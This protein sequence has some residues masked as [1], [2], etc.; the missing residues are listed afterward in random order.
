METSG[1]LDALAARVLERARD[2]AAAAVRR[3]E[4]AAARELERAE[5]QRAE[6]RHA[7]E[8]ASRT[9][10]ERRLHAARAEA[11]QSK[12]RAALNAREAAVEAV[13]EEALRRLRTADDPAGPGKRLEALIREGIAALGAPASVRVQ[14]NAAGQALARAPDFPK[15][16]DGV[17]VS[18]D[19]HAADTVGGAVVTDADGRVIFENTYEAR[20]ARSRE[21]LRRRV[22][23][24]L[25]LQ[26][27][28]ERTGA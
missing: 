11:A 28:K 26:D 22:A 5:A 13:F 16:I 6:R 7:A 17:S 3:G 8:A 14:L 12:R 1:N 24:T 20:L 10:A 19:A 23:E 2:E 21:P 15:T 9:A 27:T 18:V 4:K 25:G